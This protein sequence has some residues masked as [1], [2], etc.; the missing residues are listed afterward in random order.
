M[1]EP[2]AACLQQTFVEKR[3]AHLKE[4]ASRKGYN[5]QK[6][7]AD[8]NSSPKTKIHLASSLRKNSA[9]SDVDMR[10]ICD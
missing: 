6:I 4:D 2:P 8:T 7:I 9:P 3:D 10:R 1:T 5:S